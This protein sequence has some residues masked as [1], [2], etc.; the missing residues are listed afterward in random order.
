[1]SMTCNT[2]ESFVVYLIIVSQETLSSPTIRCRLYNRSKMG[3]TVQCYKQF[4]EEVHGQVLVVELTDYNASLTLNLVAFDCIV[5]Y[6]RLFSNMGDKTHP[7]TIIDVFP[8]IST[9]YTEN[10]CALHPAL[11]QG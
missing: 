5:L 7:F 1:M 3:S 10:N 9:T 4:C 6:L 2:S 8:R 11:H